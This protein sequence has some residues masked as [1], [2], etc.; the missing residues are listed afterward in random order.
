MQR[1]LSLTALLLYVDVHFIDSE[2][3]SVL[4]LRQLWDEGW[5]ALA[6]ADV[7]DTELAECA[8]PIKRQMLQD[9]SMAYPASLGPAVLGHSRLDSS[10][11]ASGE[12]RRRIDLVYSLLFPG[13]HDRALASGN[14]QRDAMHVA[15]AI[16]YGGYAFVTMERRLLNKDAVIRQA[17]AGF[18]IWHPNDA[19]KEAM[20]RIRGLRALHSLEPWRGQLPEL[21]DEE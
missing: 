21:P 15:T 5:L 18:R 20:D 13:V 12:D 7:L 16:R 9:L 8:D 1:A 19:L 11:I 2:L 6:R 17:F 14:H 10:V 3:P 4:R